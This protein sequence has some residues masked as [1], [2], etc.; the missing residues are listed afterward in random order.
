DRRGADRA[1]QMSGGSGRRDAD[2]ATEHVDERAAGEARIEREIDREHRAGLALAA[3]ANVERADDPGAGA[4]A[5]AERQ[6]QVADAKLA[7]VVDIGGREA[8]APRPG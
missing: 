5:R 3:A 1:L 8:P 7:I 2:D 6:N 4:G